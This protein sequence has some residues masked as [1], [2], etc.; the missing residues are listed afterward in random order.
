MSF[1]AQEQALFDLLFDRT[2]RENFIR[3]PETALAP[4]RLSPEEL[5][6]FR[7]IRP[8]ALA[9]DARLRTGLILSQLCRNFPLSFSLLSSVTDGLD[10][11][12]TLVDRETMRAPPLERATVFG[13]RL[14]DLVSETA[15]SSPEE[16]QAAAAML[17]AELGMVWTSAMLKGFVLDGGSLP[18]PPAAAAEGWLALPVRP[19][20]FVSAILIPQPYEVLKQAL[21]PCTGSELWRQLGKTPLAAADRQ[22]ILQVQ[23]PRLLVLRATLTRMSRCDPDV[24]HRTVELPEGFASLFEHLDGSGSIGDLLAGLAQ[25]GAPAALLTGV[26]AGFLQL[27]QSG[28]L[29]TVSYRN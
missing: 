2:L 4:Y 23:N 29:E 8:D 3:N 22:R 21:C 26:Q 17:D 1:A 18:P 15:F 5:D 9:F 11:L 24:D 19:A 13:M 12:Q 14:R 10:K 7:L 6:D 28:M 25:A 16:Q 20:A 27:L